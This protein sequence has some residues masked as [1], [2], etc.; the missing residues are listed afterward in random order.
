MSRTTDAVCGG[1]SNATPNGSVFFSSA[2][3]RVRISNLYFSPSG[4]SGMKSSQ[5]PAGREQP[6]RVDAAVPAVE[7][8]DHAD[9]IG[10][11]R[12]HREMHAGGR[13]D[14]DAMRAELLEHAMMR[15]FAE[16][17]QIEIGQHAAVAVGIVDLD[18]VIAGEGDAQTI[19]RDLRG[20]PASLETAPVS[21]ARCIGLS[22]PVATSRTAID[23]RGGVARADDDAS[24]PSSARCG[25]STANGSRSTDSGASTPPASLR[26]LQPT[27]QLSRS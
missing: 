20:G 23:A 24:L 10:V 17:M 3:A 4:R 25:P 7:V 13:P 14:A 18:D 12:P 1:A 21:A 9:A 22:S 11:R 19:V 26:G 15:A 5:T 16:Q 6:H 2:P 8:A 27:S